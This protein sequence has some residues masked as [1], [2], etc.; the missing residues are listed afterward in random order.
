MRAGLQPTGTPA[1]LLT[2]TINQSPPLRGESQLKLTRITDVRKISFFLLINPYRRTKN[3]KSYASIVWGYVYL[4]HE[5]ESGN[6][7]FQGKD[8]NGY[9]RG[10]IPLK[11]LMRTA[12]PL[13]REFD[14]TVVWF[15]SIVRK[16]E[17]SLHV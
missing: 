12:R 17:H 8:L 6:E 4:K 1:I 15:C 10:T 2:T 14:I 3:Y 16:D 13:V 11:W 9:L 5:G 7:R